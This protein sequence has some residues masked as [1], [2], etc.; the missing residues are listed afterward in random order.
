MD[1][2]TGLFCEQLRNHHGVTNADVPGR[3]CLIASCQPGLAAEVPEEPAQRVDK[4]EKN[5]KAV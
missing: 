1:L 2:V 3:R 5:L 4:T